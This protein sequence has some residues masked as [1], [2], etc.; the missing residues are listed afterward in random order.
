VKLKDCQFTPKNRRGLSTVVGGLIFVVLMVSAFSMFGIALETQSNMGETARIVASA[1]L[2]TQQEDFD[3]N[4]IQQGPGALDYLEVNLT[5]QGQNTAEMFSMV[6]TNKTDAGEPTQIF[7]IPYDTSFLLVNGDSAT[8]VVETLNL[9][10]DIPIPGQEENYDFKVISSMGT[11]KYMSVTCNGNTGICGVDVPPG[12]PGTASLSADLFLD[13][14]TGINS[15]D[16]TIIMFVQNTGTVPLEDVY[17]T[18]VACA[19]G[20]FPTVGEGGNPEAIPADYTSCI[21]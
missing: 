16:S 20:A 2:K 19:V 15:K 4:S 7:K 18:Q 17:P 10:M 1:Q 12:A 9:K 21:S 3:L 14:P 13:R 8:N 6:M 11:M 5:N